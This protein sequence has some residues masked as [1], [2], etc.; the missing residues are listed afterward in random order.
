MVWRSKRMNV[1]GVCKRRGSLRVRREEGVVIMETMDEA[2]RIAG[3][4][5][6][7]EIESVEWPVE[8]KGKV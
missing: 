1:H 8:L 2:R 4:T 6:P 5:Y 3:L 7:E